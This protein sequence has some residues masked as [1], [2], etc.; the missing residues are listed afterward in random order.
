MLVV[1]YGSKVLGGIITLL[2]EAHSTQ[3]IMLQITLI[4]QDTRFIIPNLT[5]SQIYY[6]FLDKFLKL[7]YL[8]TIFET[9]MIS[10]AIVCD[11]KVQQMLFNL[12]L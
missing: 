4:A 5:L 9:L 6:V 8:I 3:A 12:I 1:K 7:D 2:L 10:I 11:I